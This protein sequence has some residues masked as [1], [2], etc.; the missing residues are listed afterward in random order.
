MGSS[1]V[2]EEKGKEEEEQ[3]AEEEREELG[4]PVGTVGLPSSK[5]LNLN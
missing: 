2:A 1:Q 3:E 4:C 5:C